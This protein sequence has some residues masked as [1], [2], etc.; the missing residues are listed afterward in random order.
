MYIEA[1]RKVGGDVTQM[2]APPPAPLVRPA[3]LPARSDL[4]RLKQT[5]VLLRS[6]ARPLSVSLSVVLK[7]KD[8]QRKSRFCGS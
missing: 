7:W 6:P 1:V 3:R 4:S 2:A 5:S 8:S